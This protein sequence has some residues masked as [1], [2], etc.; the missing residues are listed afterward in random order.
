M[1]FECG[2]IAD[3]F[4]VPAVDGLS[5]LIKT[6]GLGVPT[7]GEVDKTTDV[8][9]EFRDKAKTTA[10]SMDFSFATPGNDR[11]I[12]IGFFDKTTLGEDLLRTLQNLLATQLPEWRFVIG[13]SQRDRHIGVYPE[14]IQFERRGSSIH[15]M[16]ESIRAEEL[17][18]DDEHLGVQRRQIEHVRRILSRL[19]IPTSKYPPIIVAAY[20]TYQGKKESRALWVL[21]NGYPFQGERW[22]PCDDCEDGWEGASPDF[23]VDSDRNLCKTYTVDEPV[24][25]LS[26]NL[27]NTELY[28]GKI[29]ITDP[30][31]KRQHYMEV[32]ELLSDDYVR[33]VLSMCD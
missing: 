2:G 6:P 8:I 19:D 30:K 13:A 15:Q 18:W 22:L 16:L 23:D 25:W 14:L 17:K 1:R 31:T 4:N 11:T 28:T 12:E 24:G 20:E 32:P 21:E 33:R 7:S 29:L 5:S 26:C 9:L 10:K 27:Y 3:L